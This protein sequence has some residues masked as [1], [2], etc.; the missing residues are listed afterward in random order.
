MK[1]VAI[2]LAAA[3]SLTLAAPAFA[4]API[5]KTTEKVKV[6]MKKG[7]SL[8]KPIVTLAEYEAARG[9]AKRSSNSIT[10]F[11]GSTKSSIK[12]EFTG[13]SLGPVAV[14]CGGGQG[15]KKILGITYKTEKLQYV[16]TLSGPGAGD[17][18]DFTLVFAQGGSLLK[19]LQQPQRTGELRFGGVTLRARTEQVGNVPIGGGK[20]LGYIYSQDGVDVGALDLSGD[21]ITLTA[22]SVA[23]LP[24][25]G[26]KTRD[27]AAMLSFIL[28]LFDDP[29]HQF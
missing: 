23:Y 9:I 12:F 19:A 26:A 28:F 6:G 11:G 4:D 27:A 7:K 18:A 20:V 2:G 15:K 16:C 13:P 21:G 14:S 5:T 1:T 10:G 8:F 24:A 22:P 17:D 25:K 3:I 29:G